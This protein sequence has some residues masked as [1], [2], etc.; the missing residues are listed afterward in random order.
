[1]RIGKVVQI[2][3]NPS[4]CQSVLDVVKAA[5]DNPYDG[6]SFASCVSAA[7]SSLIGVAKK[8]GIIEEPDPFL[9]DDRLRVFRGEV[10]KGGNSRVKKTKADAMYD[11]VQKHLP[12][13]ELPIMS[14][15][16][17]GS[18]DVDSMSHTLTGEEK[19]AL[20]LEYEGLNDKMNK[21]SAN[22]VEKMRYREVG[23]ML[24]F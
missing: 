11:R 24:G 2:R 5:G 8:G 12:P 21:K 9:Y 6:R 23:K 14:P 16:Y 7:L 22:N 17:E 18:K 20:F 13:P 10:G 15:E 4:D 1:M 19:E 3:I